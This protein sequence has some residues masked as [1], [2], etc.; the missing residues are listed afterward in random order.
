MP[1]AALGLAQTLLTAISDQGYTEP[2]DIQKQVIPVILSGHDVTA[3]AQT[4]TG[5][6]AGFALPIL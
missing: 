2:T 4:G 6:T 3:C 1:F 5:K